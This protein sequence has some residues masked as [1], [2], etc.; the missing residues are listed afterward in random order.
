MSSAGGA[1]I[2]RGYV[3]VCRSPLTIVGAVLDFDFSCPNA[4]SDQL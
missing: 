2:A 1:F 4:H 3:A